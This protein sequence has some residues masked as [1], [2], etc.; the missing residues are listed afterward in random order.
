MPSLNGNAVAERAQPR[1]GHSRNCELWNGIV[2]TLI[3]RFA[4]EFIGYGKGGS[5]MPA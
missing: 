4:F 3:P 2:P 5:P 1:T